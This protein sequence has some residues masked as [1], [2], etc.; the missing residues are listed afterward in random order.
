MAIHI[1]PITESTKW[2]A[3]VRRH[4]C[5]E[6][7]Y[8]SGYL[9]AFA[10]NGDGEPFLAVYENGTDYAY[11]AV[12]LRDVA[13]DKHF[14]G[15][16]EKGCY[17]DLSSPYG[18][19]GFIGAVSDW[20]ALE[21]EWDRHCEQNGYVCE[22]V[23]FHLLSEYRRHYRGDAVPVTHNVIR[24]LTQTEEE[25]W[26]DFKPKV[27]KNVKHANTCGLEFRPDPSGGRLEDFLRIYYGTMDRT[28]AKDEY[29][30][31]REF[32][33]ALS[34]MSDNVMLFHAVCEGT[35]VSSEISL[36]GSEN[37]YSFLGGTDQRYFDKRPNDFLKWEIIRYLRGIG[38]KN[39]VLGGGYGSDD[40]IFQY[41]KALAP[42]GIVDF[43]V[44]KKVFD[45]R[46]YDYLVEK[47]REAGG[48]CGDG[49]YFPGYRAEG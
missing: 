30:F 3:T 29:Y 36:I 16:L 11:N 8:L 46:K 31:P 27:R 41:K 6:P 34:G 23:R 2:D 21:K 18:Y 12:F 47:R 19:G 22:F 42:G 32:F 45:Q 20:D 35:I 28:D 24:S 7:F 25:I 10:Q 37:G 48:V 1:I 9:R 26:M 17:F 38:L 15:S 49:S 13:D 33:E 39:Y 44:G 40:G 43:Y 5:Y 4:G 14:A